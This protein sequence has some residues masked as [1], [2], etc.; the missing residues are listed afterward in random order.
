MGSNLVKA[1]PQV[2]CTG[3]NSGF[4]YVNDTMIFQ[5][6]LGGDI[7]YSKGHREAFSIRPSCHPSRHPSMDGII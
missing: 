2:L 5:E 1:H 4:K 7:T 6:G 3:F